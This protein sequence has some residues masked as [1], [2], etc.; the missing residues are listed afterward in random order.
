MV[1]TNRSEWAFGFADRVGSLTHFTPLVPS[2][3]R[4]AVVN[5]GRGRE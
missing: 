1:L 3:A 2:G 4:K 5:S